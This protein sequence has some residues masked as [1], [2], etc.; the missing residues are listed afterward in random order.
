ME[1]QSINLGNGTNATMVTVPWLQPPGWVSP[2][3]HLLN[4]FTELLRLRASSDKWVT[5]FPLSVADGRVGTPE[6][7]KLIR[8]AL[9]TIYSYRVFGKSDH[10]VVA[11]MTPAA[12][13]DCLRYRLPCYN[14]THYAK[15]RTKV[16]IYW[17]RLLVLR[18]TLVTGFNIHFSDLDVSYLRPVMPAIRKVFSWSNN[19]AD[20]SMMK[21][22]SLRPNRSPLFLINGGVKLLRSNERVIKFLDSLMP[23]KPTGVQTQ[24]A[25]TAQSYRTWA[26]CC[27]EVTCRAAQNAGMAA[28]T[29]HPMQYGPEHHCKPRHNSDICGG[30]NR[31]LYVHAICFGPNDAKESLFKN[32]KAMF[33]RT[34]MGNLTG[35]QALQDPSALGQPD[36]EAIAR[37]GL[38][39]RH[40]AWEGQRGAC[41]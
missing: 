16:D 27:T 20:G 29:P 3:T 35:L 12:V 28:L 2:Y 23:Y 10:Y 14:A 13:E 21:E 26:P 33:L 8:L 19:A 7:V 38:P 25:M 18:D 22:E 15:T 41:V 24:I 40:T 17:A 5:V 37:S 36:A 34:D 32:L 4:N 39:C 1:P 6:D 9:N 31:R 30:S 11:A